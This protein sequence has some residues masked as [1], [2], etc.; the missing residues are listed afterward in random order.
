MIYLDHTGTQPD[1]PYKTGS[2]HFLFTGMEKF[3]DGRKRFL[4]EHMDG[5]VID[6]RDDK[7]EDQMGNVYVHFISG[8]SASASEMEEMTYYGTATDNDLFV[9]PPKKK[10]HQ[11]NHFRST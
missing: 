7:F 6:K 2:C 9:G 8:S 1:E 11:L 4:P 10:S 3:I 5:P